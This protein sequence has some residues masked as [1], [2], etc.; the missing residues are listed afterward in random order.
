MQPE[1]SLATTPIDGN[2]TLLHWAAINN[3]IEIA[4]YLIN[5]RAQI[6]AF[7]GELNS[8]PLHWA[9]RDGKLQMVAFLLSH[10]AQTSLSDGEGKLIMKTTFVLSKS[11]SS[12][13]GFSSI[14]LASMFGHTDIVAYLVAK[15]QDVDLLDK[16]GMTPLMHATLRV[17]NR[18]PTQLLIQ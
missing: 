16:Q 8:T 11:N 6:D 4:E 13:I 9:I 10:Q 3:R 15:G 2:I 17:K 7:G 18:D 12:S 1:P 5:K 14:H